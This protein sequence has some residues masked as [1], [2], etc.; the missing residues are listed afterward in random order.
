MAIPLLRDSLHCNRSH[1]AQPADVPLGPGEPGC[2]ESIDQFSGDNRSHDPAADT[3]VVLIV[4]LDSLVS[5]VVVFNQPGADPR[6]LV[7]ADRGADSAAADRDAAFY[8]PAS[9]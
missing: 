9:H 8:L 3:E 7:R 6:N 2:Q 5:R 1:L 4:V